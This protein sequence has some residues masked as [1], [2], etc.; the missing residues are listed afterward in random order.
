MS[1]DNMFPTREVPPV[2]QGLKSHSPRG[3]EYVQPKSCF[4][5]TSLGTVSHFYQFMIGTLR[6]PKLPDASRC[7]P[8]MQ[9]DC[10][11]N[12]CLH[13]LLSY[14]ETASFL[15]FLIWILLGGAGELF[16][17]VVN[18]FPLLKQDTLSTLSNSA[19][20]VG[21]RVWLVGIGT[22]PQTGEPQV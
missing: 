17:F 11:V 9:V 16:C 8:C 15:P 13:M 20:I 14:S 6:R 1:C 21:F 7:Q 22:I 19:L 12:S 2:C 5:L 4:C 10:Y 18:Y 3:K